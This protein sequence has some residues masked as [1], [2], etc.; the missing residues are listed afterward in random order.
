MLPACPRGEALAAPEADVGG[1]WYDAFRLPDGRLTL[2]VGDV[3]GHGLNAAVLMGEMRHAIRAAALAGHDLAAVLHVA[4]QVLRA[5]AGGMAT[6]VVFIVDPVALRF[7]Y[8]SAG[9]PPPIL[10]TNTSIERLGQG[11][12]PLGFGEGLP[13]APEPLPLPP[14]ALLVLYTDGLIE[15]DR[16]LAGGEA[17]LQAAVAAEYAMRHGRPAQGILDRIIAGR[18]ARDDIAILTVAVAAEAG[19]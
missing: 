14:D 10:M 1:D 15:F 19:R 4:D 7:S 11:T 13:I 3:A 17:A 6:A 9:H 12:I 8:A 5:G 18:P 16:D 2:T